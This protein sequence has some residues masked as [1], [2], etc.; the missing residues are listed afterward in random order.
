MWYGKNDDRQDEAACVCKI[1]PAV[2]KVLIDRALRAHQRLAL[3]EKLEDMFFET[4]EKSSLSDAK[5]NI[6]GAIQKV[7]GIK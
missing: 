6:S 3:Q 7:L 4:L 5:D 2:Q 1:D